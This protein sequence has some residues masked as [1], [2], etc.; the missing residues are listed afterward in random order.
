MC[1][2]MFTLDN[3]L[4]FN[5]SRYFFDEDEGQAELVL[6][7]DYP[8]LEQKIITLHCKFCYIMPKANYNITCMCIYIYIYTYEE[9][10][11]SFPI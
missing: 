5:K 3:F 4:K 1:S 6:V 11:G 10:F 8:L 9:V 2:F 7:L